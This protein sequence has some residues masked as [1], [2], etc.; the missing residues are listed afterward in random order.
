M[1]CLR[2]GSR[3]PNRSAVCPSC[4]TR[5]LA[6]SAEKPKKRQPTALQWL[7]VATL[8]ICLISV[9]IIAAILLDSA[10]A[11]QSVGN[12]DTIITTKATASTTVR[13]EAHISAPII[14]QFPDYPTGCESVAAVM[15][16]QYAGESIT[17]EEF[18]R[19]YLPCSL[20]FYWYNGTYYGPS[21][22]EYFL[23]N[24]RSKNSYGCMAPV[25][26][27]ALIQH[28]GSSER[29]ID[30]TGQDMA[31]L[32]DTYVSRGI[33]VIVWVSINMAEV[34][35]GRQ[36]VLPDGSTF[37]WPSGE[38]CMLLIGYDTEH[39]YFNDPY[40]G[41]VV[42]YSRTLSESRYAQMGKQA[43]VIS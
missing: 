24:P 35:N 21:P 29:L 3:L 14:H 20:D 39:Y 43:L 40:T 18:I 22:Y 16:L 17:V 7:I 42:C 6:L 15:A 19:E 4:G 30:A 33:P 23:G 37:A 34:K 11:T 10:P 41:Q 28:F 5:H 12:T 8:L 31:S 26:K 13:Q 27:K 2:C 38:H 32:C 36:W 1:V 9:A 25:I